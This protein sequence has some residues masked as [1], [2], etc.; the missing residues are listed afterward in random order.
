VIYSQEWSGDRLAV[1]PSTVNALQH[2]H[3]EHK[4][5]KFTLLVK[6]IIRPSIQKE[7]IA[8][9]LKVNDDRHVPEPRCSQRRS[10]CAKQLPCSCRT[11]DQCNTKMAACIPQVKE[12]AEGAKGNIRINLSKPLTDNLLFYRCARWHGSAHDSMC[13]LDLSFPHFL[14]KHAM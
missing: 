12:E 1:E 9:W 14:F 4:D 10:C 6:Y 7:F 8:A 13:T 2:S 11:N 3:D 5:F